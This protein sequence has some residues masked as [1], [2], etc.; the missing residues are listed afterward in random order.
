VP[1]LSTVRINGA[2]IGRQGA[3]FLIER[4]EGR[5]VSP[6]LLDVG[7]TIVERDTT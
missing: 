4:A 3:R 1:S 2:D 6:S 7:F 5:A